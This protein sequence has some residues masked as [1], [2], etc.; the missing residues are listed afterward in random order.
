MK[1]L[2]LFAFIFLETSNK[3]VIVDPYR[4]LA[5]IDPA[6]IIVFEYNNDFE[7]KAIE[8]V[9]A[10]SDDKEQRTDLQENY[11]LSPEM[12]QVLDYWSTFKR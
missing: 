8:V 7:G 9:E 11:S 2:I 3:L 10:E 12:E 6:D 5:N 1:R 4:E